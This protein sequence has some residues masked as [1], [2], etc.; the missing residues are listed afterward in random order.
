MEN[1]SLL[2]EKITE[3]KTCPGWKKEGKM[4]ENKTEDK[5]HLGEIE[6]MKALLEKD[7][8]ERVDK[9]RIELMELLKKYNCAFDV[10]AILTS[11]TPINPQGI[12]FNI[13]I[14]SQS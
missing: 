7:K 3:A 14:V 12:R 11:P 2:K 8:I 6:Q 9:C 10:S 5:N 4:A 13:N 1:K